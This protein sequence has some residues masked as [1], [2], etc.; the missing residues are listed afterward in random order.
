MTKT[1]ESTNHQKNLREEPIEEMARVAELE[2]NKEH[3]N[4]L[5]TVMNLFFSTIYGIKIS[6]DKN[7]NQSF[8]I[9]SREKSKKYKRGHYKVDTNNDLHF[10]IVK[11]DTVDILAFDITIG[12]K[13]NLV[14]DLP[15]LIENIENLHNQNIKN[16]GKDSFLNINHAKETALYLRYLTQKFTEFIQQNQ[17]K[18][19]KAD[20]KILNIIKSSQHTTSREIDTLEKYSVSKQVNEFSNILEAFSRIF[21]KDDTD[22]NVG[23]N[24]PINSKD[25]IDNEIRYYLLEKYDEEWKKIEEVLSKLL[26]RL[27]EKLNLRLDRNEAINKFVQRIIGIISLRAKTGLIENLEKNLMDILLEIAHK[28]LFE[29]AGLN[30]LKGRLGTEQDYTDVIKKIYKISDTHW[31]VDEIKNNFPEKKDELND[32][33]TKLQANAKQIEIAKNSS[34]INE[35]EKL[36]DQR[37]KL[38]KELL[39]KITLIVFSEKFFLYENSYHSFKSIEEENL[40]NCVARDKLIHNLWKYYTGELSLSAVTIDHIFPV[41]KLANGNLVVAEQVNTKFNPNEYM[42][43]KILDFGDH[44]RINTASQLHW[45]AQNETDLKKTEILLRMTLELSPKKISAIVNLA[46]LLAY[47]KRH[48]EAEE[49]Y[50]KAIKIYPTHDIAIYN[51]ANLLA[52]NPKRHQEAEWFYREAIALS[53]DNGRYIC[54]L[55]ELLFD[56]PESREEAETLYKKALKIDK[57]NAVYITKLS[58]IKK[59]FF[60]LF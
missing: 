39:N 27:D 18:L 15:S 26:P 30:K 47:F 12:N 60:N 7:L 14:K 24:N 38:Q 2:Y 46:N 42:G 5:I 31:Y 4:N 21:V 54:E 1:I 8:R 22:T 3:L 11:E 50:R 59:L 33:K 20:R 36:K 34:N 58:T 23:K 17:K 10:K 40:V 13:F 19:E 43:E 29:K 9:D 51:L 57:N 35:I 25:Q 55:A 41:I 16:K 28:M 45:L 37:T 6:H 32:L 44:N 48:K 52:K 53:P 56:Y 49:L